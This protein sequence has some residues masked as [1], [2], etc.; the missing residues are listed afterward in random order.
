MNKIF[1]IS[2][3][4]SG[5]LYHG[6]TRLDIY[7]IPSFTKM[8]S[9]TNDFIIGSRVRDIAAA[10]LCANQNLFGVYAP[11]IT[12][13]EIAASYNPKHTNLSLELYNKVGV[14]NG[15]NKIWFEVLID[16][17]IC[18]FYNKFLLAKYLLGINHGDQFIITHPA[19]DDNEYGYFLHASPLRDKAISYILSASQMLIFRPWFF[20]LL[21]LVFLIF[22]LFKKRLSVEYACLYLSGAF[23]MA[24]IILFGNAADARLIFYSNSISVLLL[25]LSIGML[26][27]GKLN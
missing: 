13:S 21:N 12:V 17:P 5:L 3:L 14:T 10:S 24:G 11:N 23:Y 2:F 7:I 27:G 8:E 20:H 19:I 25:F 4:L 6:K 15:I 9:S 1:L 26:R 22:L 16:H 18:I